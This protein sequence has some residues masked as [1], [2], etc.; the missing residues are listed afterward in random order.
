MM[1][2]A[3]SASRLRFRLDPWAAE[4]GSELPLADPAGTVPAAVDTNVER[5]AEAWEPL[6]PGPGAEES[7]RLVF[8]DGVRRIEARVLARDGERVI[9]GA[10]GTYAVGAVVVEAGRAA[11]WAACRVSRVLAL[12][13]G[14][15]LPEPYFVPWGSGAGMNPL[16][17]PGGL[18]HERRSS[19]PEPPAGA[20]YRPV[21]AADDDPD[22]PVRRLQEEMRLAEETLGEEESRAAGTLVV[23]DGPLRFRDA[24]GAAVGYVKRLFERHGVPLPVLAALSPGTRTPLIALEGDRFRRYTWFLRLAARGPAD[25]DLAGIVRLEVAETVGLDAAKRLADGTA[26]RLPGFAPSRQR[27]PRSPQNLLPIGALEQRLRREMGDPALARRHIET[28]L[29]RE[30]RA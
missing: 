2:A 28:A 12:G 20:V 16:P 29:A 21:S 19:A 10:F 23:A 30:A 11:A 24:R 5:S 17:V 4:Y 9:P 14:A 26:R 15:S 27:D 1:P 8:V 25:F 18:R 6:A 22:A 13:A 3:P 7:A